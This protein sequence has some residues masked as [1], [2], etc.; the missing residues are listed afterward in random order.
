MNE[1]FLAFVWKYQK[2]PS[3]LATV[4]DRTLSILKTGY[5]NPNE[6]PDFLE[7]TILLD[8]VKWVGSIELHVKSSDW[9]LHKHDKNPNYENVILHVVWENDKQI[10][11]ANGELIPTIEL[12]EL[13][14]PQLTERYNKLLESNQ[15]LLCHHSI[16]EVSPILKTQTK[17]VSL[18]K[19]MES[20]ANSI[21]HIYHASGSDL[22]EAWY[23][24]LARAFGFK[25]NADIMQ[26]LAIKLP[27]KIISKHLLNQHQV[28]ALLFG[29][30]GLL[31]LDGDEY[32]N[33]LR[34]EFTYL[35]HKYDLPI[36][37]KNN[38]MFART[39]PSN[40][41]TIRLAQFAT[42]LVH[43]H[44]LWKILEKDKKELFS[45]FKIKPSNYWKTHYSFG[46]EN[47]SIKKSG[48][49]GDHASN[50]LAINAIVP[51]LF[52]YSKVRQDEKVAEKAFD[53][54]TMFSPENNYKT[55][56]YE[57][58]FT[59]QSAYD[60]QSLIG[61]YDLLCTQKKCL[62]CPIGMNIINQNIDSTAVSH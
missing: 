28:E 38:W 61:L 5:L 6:G 24:W 36:M 16:Q 55:R 54:L 2:M 46:Q 53:Y 11:R 43:N 39:R 4:D 57:G 40:F 7:A 20:K 22:T 1:E 8:E 21:N 29:V 62:E 32:I 13:I 12:K 10:K 18:I 58:V 30:S 50:L 45:L 60:S 48:V 56:I 33:S 51:F 35:A 25:L 26:S 27:Y 47:T 9:N 19:R 14:Y 49:I 41:P 52:F 15:T 59:H 44:D 23:I 31:P 3:N 37:K 34:K 17:E 42:F